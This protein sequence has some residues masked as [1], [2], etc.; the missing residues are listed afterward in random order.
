MPKLVD[1]A[2]RFDFLQEAAFAVV[3]DQGTGALSRRALAAAMGT[4]VN[5]VRRLL[6]ADASLA[7]LAAKEVDKRRRHGR[8]GGRLRDAEPRPA[9]LHLLRK[10]L[11]DEERR[12]AEEF[13]WFRLLLEGHRLAVPHD[14]TRT[15]LRE[16]FR[17][18]QHGYVDEDLAADPD[19]HGGPEDDDPLADHR[20]AR[21]QEIIWLVH[22]ALDLLGV[23]D[24][25]RA[26]ESIRIRALLDGLSLAVCL[27]RLA[28]EQALAALEQH[29]DHVHRGLG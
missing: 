9:A 28:P 2:V 16:R 25:A 1:Y 17:V 4:S 18:A 21:E 7:Q 14:E 15:G 26:A 24:H 11:P 5:T 22:E 3:R 20:T 23:P 8:Y 27:G 12:V 29:L 13:V 19:T 6:A 10:L